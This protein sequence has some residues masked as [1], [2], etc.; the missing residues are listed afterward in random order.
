MEVELSE[1]LFELEIKFGVEVDRVMIVNHI[2]SYFARYRK[3]DIF[4]RMENGEY[5]FAHYRRNEFHRECT[6]AE[7][8][9]NTVKSLLRHIRSFYETEA[10]LMQGW[11]EARALLHQVVLS[12]VQHVDDKEIFTVHQSGEISYSLKFSTAR[13]PKSYLSKITAGGTIPLYVSAVDINKAE[14]KIEANP[15]SMRIPEA[16]ITK[17]MSEEGRRVGYLRSIKRLVGRFS[18]IASEVIIDK[19]MVEEA[20]NIIGEKISIHHLT[21]EQLHEILVLKKPLKY[22]KRG[23]DE[24]KQAKSYQHRQGGWARQGFWNI[25]RFKTSERAAVFLSLIQKMMRRC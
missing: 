14:L 11:R 12:N 4:C 10:Y 22:L 1:Y 17:I 2:N 15:Y 20:G 24:K 3:G 18:N 9:M 23:R 8:N 6:I 25:W 16:I 5:Y 19:N 7:M 13:L 21:A